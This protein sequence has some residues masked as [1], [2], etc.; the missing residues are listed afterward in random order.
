M[1]AALP[2]PAVLRPGGPPAQRARAATL[3]ALLRRRWTSV[4]AV[5]AALAAW[6]AGS[7]SGVLPHTLFPSMSATFGRL[8]GLLVDGGFW[9]A[10]GLTVESWV[11]G[12]AIATALALPTGMLLGRVAIAYRSARLMV[13]FLRTIPSVSVIPLITLLFGAS[14][15]MKVILVVYGSF[16]PLML[17]M[18]YGVRDTD[19][20]LI[21]TVRSYRLSRWSAA[22][23]VLAPSAL[24]Y[25]VTG[26]RISVVVGLLLAIS[27]EILG[28]AP[29]I[30]LELALA[31]G[32]GDLSLT[33]A[34]IVFIGLVGV[35]L[36]LALN[37]ASRIVLFWH[38][39]VRGEEQ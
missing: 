21:D 20:V 27:S 1:A 24:P 9:Y 2:G 29:G 38:P 35:T 19:R 7:A 30:G 5:A 28:S 31:Q 22:R 14:M 32:G 17:Q 12:V 10:F 34:Y 4:V 6:E 33:Y 23:H 37:A 16:W 25:V 39:S 18:V 36:D 26:L 13:D 15:E 8:G 11:I 3:P